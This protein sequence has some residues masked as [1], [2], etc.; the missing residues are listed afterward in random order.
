MTPSSAPSSEFQRGLIWE[1]TQLN[2]ERGNI[3]M[4]K[5]VLLSV[6]CLL[7]LLVVGCGGGDD[8]GPGPGT[9]AS[10]VVLQAKVP[11]G[12]LNQSVRLAMVPTDILVSMNGTPLEY[13][14]TTDGFMIFQ[15]TVSVSDA[16]FSSI[17]ASGG[18]A[19]SLTIQI[20]TRA[21]LTLTITLDTTTSGSP[22]KTVALTISI[23]AGQTDG[24]FTIQ[25]TGGTGVIAP[26]N[27]VI[28]EKSLGVTGIEY[29]TSSGDFLPL[30]NATGVPFISTTIRVT[31]DSLVDKA[32]NSFKILAQSKHGNQVS[33]MQNDLGKILTIT[34]TD[35]PTGATP[36]HSFLDVTLLVNSTEGKFFGPATSYTLSF[37]SASVCRKDDPSIRL[38]PTLVFKR[39]FTTA[40]AQ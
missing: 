34:Q 25:I 7:A 38:R 8:S 4:K 28:T 32:T 21:P 3:E 19:A 36:A 20:G 6:T 40:S 17:L 26:A 9:N 23:A 35:L 12:A 15:K 5:L 27:P 14:T 31:F 1:T 37:E 11:A 10:S 22:S 18:G 29:R 16:S 33:L 13:S 2:L 24:T 30:A 39:T